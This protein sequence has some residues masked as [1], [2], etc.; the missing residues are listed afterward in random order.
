[1]SFN[2]SRHTPC[3]VNKKVL[4]FCRSGTSVAKPINQ[5]Q[6]RLGEYAFGIRQDLL[7]VKL[8]IFPYREFLQSR[9]D[10]MFID[11]RLHHPLSPV[12]TICVEQKR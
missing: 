2:S 6:M 8:R 3:A 1:M 11:I 9:R 12:G 4:W 5:R 10:D 7:G